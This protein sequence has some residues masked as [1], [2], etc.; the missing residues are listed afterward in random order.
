MRH[1]ENANLHARTHKD[2][3]ILSSNGRSNTGQGKPQG[4]MFMHP[5]TQNTLIVGG[6]WQLKV[7]LQYA[8]RLS[9][10]TIYR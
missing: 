7:L 5:I 10:G 8:K 4:G 6:C 9:G 1:Y 3:Y 2:N